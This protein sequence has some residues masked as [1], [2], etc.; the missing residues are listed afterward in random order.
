MRLWE[1]TK[2]WR[3]LGLPQRIISFFFNH[4]PYLF[5][6]FCLCCEW[7]FLTG[8][9]QNSAVILVKKCLFSSLQDFVPRDN[10]RT[11]LPLGLRGMS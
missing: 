5:K 7:P 1:R 8:V 4:L 3:R 9:L 6:T 2:I 11:T 10:H